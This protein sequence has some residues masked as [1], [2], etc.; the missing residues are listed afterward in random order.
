MDDTDRDREG[1]GRQGVVTHP[2]VSLLHSNVGPLLP[3]LFPVT[4][5]SWRVGFR[6][7][8]MKTSKMSIKSLL[9][10]RAAT[11]SQSKPIPGVVSA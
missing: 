8:E 3:T 4:P 10:A 5:G 11:T 9:E 6:P 2:Y 7:S 1:E